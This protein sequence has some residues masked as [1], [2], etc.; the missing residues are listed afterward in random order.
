MSAK[1]V[2]IST[3]SDAD[4]DRDHVTHYSHQTLS[5]HTNTLVQYK[6]IIHDILVGICPIA[7]LI[8]PDDFY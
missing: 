3:C 1:H 6:G 4:F 2:T 5:L 8:S 7:I